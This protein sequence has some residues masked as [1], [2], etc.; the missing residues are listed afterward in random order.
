M[1]LQAI[2]FDLDGTIAETETIHLQCFNEAFYH[3]GLPYRWTFEEYRSLLEI[4]DGQERILH[5]LKKLNNP[6]DHPDDLAAGLHKL[7]NELYVERMKAGFQVRPG[8]RRLLEEALAC[9]I[10]CGLTTMT[11][12]MNVDP[13]LRYSLAEDYLKYFAFMLTGSEIRH[14]KPD[15]AIY[16]AAKQM[17]LE[18]DRR[19]IIVIEDSHI[20]LLAA[21][22]AGLPV[23][24]TQNEFT[25]HHDFSGA[26]AVL[27]DLGDPEKPA[28]LIKGPALL[29]GYADLAFLDSLIV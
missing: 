28:R 9:N 22:S 18:R 26:A 19:N 5:Y 23:L 1:R 21:R 6:P 3:F 29:N 24:I 4:A 15:P 11:S 10:T 7:K 13:L 14:K 8:V 12:H 17:L 27:S 2:L 16:I 25:E 20:G